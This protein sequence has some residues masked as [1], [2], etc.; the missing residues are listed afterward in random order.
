MGIGSSIPKVEE[1]SR[2][3]Q[4]REVLKHDKVDDCTPC[5]I[6]GAAAFMGLGAYSYFSGHSQLK[7]QQAKILNS[8]SI[9][10]MRSRQAGITSIAL[11]LA[12]MGFWR[13]V[14]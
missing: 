8:K 6:T 4:L 2:P 10:G 9:F 5:R 13:L 14:N 3:E 7:S 12:G 1:L 11:T